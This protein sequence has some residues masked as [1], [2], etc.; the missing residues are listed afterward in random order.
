MSSRRPSRWTIPKNENDNTS[1]DSEPTQFSLILRCTNLQAPG[2]AGIR[3]HP[4]RST[5]KGTCFHILMHLTRPRLALRNFSHCHI[6]VWGAHAQ[7][8][9][10]NLKVVRPHLHTACAAVNSCI[11]VP[12]AH[13]SLQPHLGTA[14]RRIRPVAPSE[15]HPCT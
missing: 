7:I 4:N 13:T 6:R 12:L 15:Q 9:S 10:P 8:L 5:K 1:G 11:F 14:K 2:N 3:A